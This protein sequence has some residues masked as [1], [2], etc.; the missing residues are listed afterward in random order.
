M[1]SVDRGIAS[2]TPGIA[3]YNLGVVLEK[4][5][6]W[7][8]QKGRLYLPFNP[9]QFIYRGGR[10]QADGPP[11]MKSMAALRE[12]S[13]SKYNSFLRAFESPQ[14]FLKALETKETAYGHTQERTFFKNE[15]LDLTPRSQ[16]TWAW[17]DYAAFWWSYG[18][19]LDR[20]PSGLK[21]Q[22]DRLMTLD[23]RILGR[24]VERWIINGRNGTYLV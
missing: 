15:D 13:Q 19:L 22:V 5:T 18:M 4:G 10:Q 14:Q 21:S 9:S 23:S 6:W 17:Y 1:Q 16:W 24:C 2:P 12:R 3:A 11:K 20:S 7:R 8:R